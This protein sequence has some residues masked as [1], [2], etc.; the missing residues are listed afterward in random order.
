M[1]AARDR[2]S[3]VPNVGDPWMQPEGQR[4]HLYCVYKFR[5]A[6]D[7]CVYVGQTSDLV[8][9]I[10]QRHFG[11]DGTKAKPWWPEVGRVEVEHFPP[12]T[13]RREV[14]VYERLQIESLRPRYNN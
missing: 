7:E 14:E 2:R 9:R 1:A 11:G 8:R 3:S 10:R 6:N 13:T 4:H 12:G 5:D